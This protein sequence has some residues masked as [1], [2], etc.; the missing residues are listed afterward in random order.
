MKISL[1]KEQAKE[2]LRLQ[3]MGDNLGLEFYEKQFKANKNTL[4]P[5]DR[6]FE[7][8]VIISAQYLNSAIMDMEMGFIKYNGMID[9]A[10]RDIM[11]ELVESARKVCEYE[12]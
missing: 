2:F 4:P 8:K 11:C 12:V 1:N 5:N 9:S 7:Q 6:A 10:Y 3:E